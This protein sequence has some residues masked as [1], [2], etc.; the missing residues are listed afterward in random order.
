M[1]I[2]AGAYRGRSLVAPGVHS[3][4][5]TADRTRQALFNVLEHAAWAPDLAGAKVADIFAGSGAFGLE[6]L[7]RGA[8]WCLFVDSAAEPARVI[9]DNLGNLGLSSKARTE[10]RDATRVSEPPPEAPFDLIF[11]DPPYAAGLAEPALAVLR[12]GWLAEGSLV[13][14]ER[15]HAELPLVAPGFHT[16]DHRAWGAARVSFLALEG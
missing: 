2:I 6:A 10:R 11:L 4:R 5:P 13:V 8:A 7:S 9:R 14:V 16:L 12:S 1:R 3:T 15:G